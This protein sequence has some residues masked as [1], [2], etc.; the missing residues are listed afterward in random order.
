DNVA[1]GK[2]LVR[3]KVW[4]KGSPEPEQ[5]TIEREDPIPNQAGAPGFYAYAHNEVYYDNIKVSENSK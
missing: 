4:L 3:G 2:A 1:G 5:W